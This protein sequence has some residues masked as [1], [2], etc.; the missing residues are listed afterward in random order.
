MI[1]GRELGFLVQI[2][3]IPM[4]FKIGNGVMHRI[5]TPNKCRNISV[6][7]FAFAGLSLDAIICLIKETNE[8]PPHVYRYHI[9]TYLYCLYVSI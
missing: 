4:C 3:I 2:K 6:I 1:F 8:I 7:K 5:S 9:D